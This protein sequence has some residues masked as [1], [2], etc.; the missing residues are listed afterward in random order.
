MYFPE[1]PKAPVTACIRFSFIALPQPTII[2]DKMISIALKFLDLFPFNYGLL[3]IGQ[4]P[5]SAAI[6]NE[7]M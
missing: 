6:E 1:Y 7:K 4:D 5:F 2:I 3:T